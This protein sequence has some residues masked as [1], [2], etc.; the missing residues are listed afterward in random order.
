MGR[1][2]GGCND[3]SYDRGAKWESNVVGLVHPKTHTNIH[4]TPFRSQ[5]AHFGRKWERFRKK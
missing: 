2:N 4:C 5:I 1:K 3:K